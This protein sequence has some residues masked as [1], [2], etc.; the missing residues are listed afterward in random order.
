M[1]WLYHQEDK[2]RELYKSVQ[3][4]DVNYRIKEMQTSMRLIEQ[5]FLEGKHLIVPTDLDLLIQ[6]CGL[7]LT[8]GDFDFTI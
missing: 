7:D 4:A 3:K 2:L 8:N 6:I 1:L 5:N